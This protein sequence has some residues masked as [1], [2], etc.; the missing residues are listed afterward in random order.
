MPL[1]AI[2]HGSETEAL[3]LLEAIAHNCSC[4]LIATRE[5]MGC[6]AHTMIAYD[7]RTLDGLLFARRMAS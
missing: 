6:S 3:E 7:Q 2:W 4:E 5:R 1:P